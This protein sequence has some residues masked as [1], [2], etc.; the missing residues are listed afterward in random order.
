MQQCRINVHERHARE[1][2]NE[3]HKLVQITRAQDGNEAAQNRDGGTEGILLPLCGRGTLA[4][5]SFAEEGRFDNAGGGE[6]LHWC[7]DEDGHGIEKLHGVDELAA[8]GEIGDDFD[9]GFVAEGG[10]AEGADGG[11]DDGYDYHDDVEKAGEFFR[12][13]HRGLDGQDEADAFEGED[14]GADSEGEIAGVKQLDCW[15]Q[16]FG[17]EGGDVV[18]PDVDQAEENEDVS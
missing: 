8:L 18:V 4:G 5:G 11:E 16:A 17:S 9:A 15:M 7:A 2:A 6:E 1:A 12:L 3:R 13:R 14:G 10:V